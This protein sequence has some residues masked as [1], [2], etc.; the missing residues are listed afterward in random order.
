M[1]I[2]KRIKE[3]RKAKNLTLVELSEA[4]GVQVATLSRIE[5]LKMSGTLESHMAIAKA[6]DIDITQ[7]YTD[8]IHAEAR[9]SLT[10]EKTATDFFSHSDKSSYEILT[11]KVLSKKMMPYLLKVEPNGKTNREQNTI[12]SEKFVYVLEGKLSVR[13][14]KE[15]FE[16]SKGNS[17]YF[18]ASKEHVMVNKGKTAVRALC[19]VTPVSL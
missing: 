3:L 10:N 14:D 16:L 7:L 9:P 18:D 11:T 13:V 19:V 6:L 12:G 4:S 2:G 8:I 1:Y 15:N 17:L 5:N